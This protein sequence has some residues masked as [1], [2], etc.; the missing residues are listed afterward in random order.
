MWSETGGADER[1]AH[2][3]SI[4]DM[5]PK[6]SSNLIC[7]YNTACPPC[8]LFVTT[9]GS[10]GRSLVPWFPGS[11]SRASSPTLL[12]FLNLSG[13]TTWRWSGAETFRSGKFRRRGTR[14]TLATR[15]GVLGLAQLAWRSHVRREPFARF[16]HI[17]TSVVKPELRER[18]CSA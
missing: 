18:T 2:N 16:C 9:F 11:R 14:R 8:W 10:F 1:L 7:S 15:A 13:R 4:V 3:A 17:I 6:L 12:R 5:A